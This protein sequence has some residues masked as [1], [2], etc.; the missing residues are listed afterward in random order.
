MHKDAHQNNF[1]AI[2]LQNITI[3]A[4]LIKIQV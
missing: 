3:M 4:N 2:D 1:Q